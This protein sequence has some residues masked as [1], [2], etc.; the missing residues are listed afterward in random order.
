MT[1]P[2]LPVDYSNERTLYLGICK[3]IE[4]DVLRG[5]LT[6]GDSLPTHRELADALGVAIGTVTRAYGVAE[7]LGLIEGRGRS[8]T[9]VRDRSAPATS[10]SRSIAEHSCAHLEA[11]TLP[12]GVSVPDF[13]KTLMRLLRKRDKGNARYWPPESNRVEHL[14][15][16]VKWFNFL[17]MSV[18]DTDLVITPGNH[19]GI[20]AALGT[21]VSAGDA[22]AA[23][24]HTYIGLKSICRFLGL[25]L[26]GIEMD[27]QGMIPDALE[28]ACR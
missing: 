16:G 1:K 17:G 4:R 25:R 28:S 21:E 11:Y 26:Y 12:Y 24:E 5:E 13:E 6:P 22:I 15:T 3:A 7:Q 20:L 23:E 10:L 8:G 27:S 18:S 9:F 19:H 2:W 14:Q